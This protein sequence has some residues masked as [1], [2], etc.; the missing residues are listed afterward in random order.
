MVTTH[1]QQ[2]LGT[3]NPWIWGDVNDDQVANFDDIQR[4]VLAF[5]GDFGN[6]TLEAL[7]LWPCLPDRMI[8]FDDI[9]RAVLAFE[10]T[11]FD[12]SGCLSPCP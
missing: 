9:Q 12:E 5:E 4:M 10:G 1:E 7:D 3:A 6:A 8:N 2:Y 11:S